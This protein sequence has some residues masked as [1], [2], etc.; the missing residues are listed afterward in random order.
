M[1]KY[2]RRVIKITEHLELLKFTKTFLCFH[3]IKL[4]S[5]VRTFDEFDMQAK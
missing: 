5:I 2:I 4:F 3:K 1:V